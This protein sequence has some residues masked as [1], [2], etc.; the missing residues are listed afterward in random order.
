MDEERTRSRSLMALH[1]VISQG[2]EGTSMPAC[3]SLSEHDRWSLAFHVGTLAFKDTD[4]EA[5]QSA[6]AQ[7][8]AEYATIPA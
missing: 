3:A 4:L 5:G 8:K 6:F 7:D 2:V 1:Q